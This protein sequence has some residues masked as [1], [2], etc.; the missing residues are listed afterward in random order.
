MTAIDQFPAKCAKWMKMSR[1]R[2]TNNAEV[3]SEAHPMLRTRGAIV[4]GRNCA[5]V[6][7]PILSP[8]RSKLPK[9]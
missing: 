6:F 5:Y 7:A 9:E 2:W 4:S 8:L 3:H 1:N